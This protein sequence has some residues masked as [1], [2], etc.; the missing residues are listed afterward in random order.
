MSV[1]FIYYALRQTPR[2]EGAGKR[3]EEG[4]PVAIAAGFEAP[5]FGAR[6]VGQV[7]TL[8]LEGEDGPLV[9]LTLRGVKTSGAPPP[10]RYVHA[11]PFRIP[12]QARCTA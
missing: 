1:V 11:Q 4:E 8:A 5:I 7:T 6:T 3:D 9:S 2:S 10:A 12:P